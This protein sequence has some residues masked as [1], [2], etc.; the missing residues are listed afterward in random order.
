MLNEATLQPLR[1]RLRGPLIRPGD[2]DYD[3][4]R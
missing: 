4:A 2:A 3:R 1:A